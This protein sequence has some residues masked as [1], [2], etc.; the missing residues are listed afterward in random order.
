[1]NFAIDTENYRVQILGDVDLSM[2]IEVTKKIDKDVKW[3][4][5]PKLEPRKTF[6]QRIEEVAKQ[7]VR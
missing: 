7:K 5:C 3:T 4:M 6:D 1:M 2:I